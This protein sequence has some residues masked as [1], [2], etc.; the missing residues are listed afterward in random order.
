MTGPSQT[1][2]A[3]KIDSYEDAFAGVK[4]YVDRGSFSTKQYMQPQRRQIQWMLRAGDEL[5]INSTAE[6]GGVMRQVAMI[7]DGYR[8]TPPIPTTKA[9]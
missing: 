5:G 4:R 6:G 1:S 2:G 8:P 3:I 7:I 9:E